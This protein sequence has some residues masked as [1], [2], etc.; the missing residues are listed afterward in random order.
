MPPQKHRAPARDSWDSVVAIK[1]LV[2]KQTLEDPRTSI[3]F[4]KITPKPTP[5]DPGAFQIAISDKQVFYKLAQ[6][7]EKT[8]HTQMSLA[9]LVAPTDWDGH[10]TKTMWML[11]WAGVKGFLPVKPVVALI[12]EVTVDGNVSIMF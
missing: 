12:Q 10:I 7:E 2:K 3:A 11:R 6:N 4:H 9:G 5:D 8:K 1:E